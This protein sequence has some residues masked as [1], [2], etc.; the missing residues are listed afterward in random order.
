MCVNCL[1][2]KSPKLNS[3]NFIEGMDYI[4]IT[5]PCG[6]CE[7][8]KDMKR[9]GVYVRL[10]YEFKECQLLN[11]VCL[12]LTLTYNNNCLPRIEHNGVS[13][14]CFNTKDLQ[15]YFKR[16]RKFFSDKGIEM[17]FTYFVAYE[18]GGKTHRPHYHVLFFI[19]RRMPAWDIKLF[20]RVMHEKWQYGY[21]SVGK[22]GAIVKSAH[23]LNYAA[24]Y[25]AKD[26]YDDTWYYPLIKD[27]EECYGKGDALN[28]YKRALSG[29]FLASRGLGLFALRDN[30]M[31][32]LH[33]LEIMAPYDGK[34][35]SL[36]LP[37]Y[38]DRKLHYDVL[39]RN[40]VNGLF[41]DTRQ[42]PDD[43]PTYVLN[44]SGMYYIKQRFDKKLSYLTDRLKEFLNTSYTNE[45]I[46]N[47]CRCLCNCSVADVRKLLS[48]YAAQAPLERVAAYQI[49]YLHRRDYG[50]AF[51]DCVEVSSSD[52]LCDY[53][54]LCSASVRYDIGECREYKW[55][56]LEKYYNTPYSRDANIQ[57]YRQHS[58]AMHYEMFALNA[59]V[60]SFI[61]FYLSQCHKHDYELKVNANKSY[62]YRKS[63]REMAIDQYLNMS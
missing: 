1:T 2:I 20:I 52:M 15:K 27:I 4:R 9:Q 63:I 57:V 19:K 23:A 21:T 35:Q 54:T 61:S 56:F 58:T 17:P 3:P 36:P 26:A 47:S 62:S 40:R 12:N 7:E 6:H 8:C 22:L 32:R 33:R 53:M 10:Y 49:L 30:Q 50:A 48:D 44:Q 39:Y 11:G 37:L 43:V 42:S 18:L 16:I 46:E 5:V 38:L 51:D 25:V 34:M 55:D 24:K 13:Y 29:R 31:W 60:F 28:W 59:D 41:S 14:P 45:F